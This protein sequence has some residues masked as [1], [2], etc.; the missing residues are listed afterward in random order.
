MRNIQDKL[1]ASATLISTG[2]SNGSGI[3]YFSEK[4][5]YLVT[6]KHVLFKNDKLISDEIETVSQCTDINDESVHRLR[7]NLNKLKY[8]FHKTDDV[9][10]V[11]IGFPKPNVKNLTM[12]HFEGIEKLEKGSSNPGLIR[13]RDTLKFDEVLISND[14]FVL[15]YPT[16]IGLKHLPQFNYNK[17]LL[18]RGIISSTF[19]EANTIILDC[20]SYGGNSGGPVI[21]VSVDVDKKDFKL[22]GIVSQYIPYVQKW[23]NLRD[24]IENVEYLNSGYS[25]AV[26]WDSVKEIVAEL[27]KL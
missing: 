5:L 4:N 23:C 21:Q 17:P 27:D 25:V 8:L 26:S 19:K 16:S 13:E 9:C 11:Q 7:I 20:P 10:V 2:V 22:I 24:G 18:R 1:L 3:I 6:A 15:G 14:V 12:L